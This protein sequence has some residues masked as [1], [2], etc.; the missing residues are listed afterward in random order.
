MEFLIFRKLY[1]VYLMEVGCKFLLL[2]LCTH[3]RYLLR[4]GWLLIYDLSFF[5]FENLLYM[6]LYLLNFVILYRNPFH[7]KDFLMILNFATFK[8]NSFFLKLNESILY[9]YTKI[10]DLYFSFLYLI[11]YFRKIFQHLNLKKNLNR[12]KWSF[13]Y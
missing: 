3:Q 8:K 9:Q 6:Y 4:A 5:H 10:K 13:I 1:F 12:L 7:F 11:F 2:F